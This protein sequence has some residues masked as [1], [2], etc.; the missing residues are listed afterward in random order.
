MGPDCGGRRVFVAT[1]STLA[2]GRTGICVCWDCVVRVVGLDTL[3]PVF[4]P[5]SA[6]AVEPVH[7]EHVLQ[8]TA[9]GG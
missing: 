1:R 4:L 6:P 9:V 5:E 2:S 3:P 8:H 7:C